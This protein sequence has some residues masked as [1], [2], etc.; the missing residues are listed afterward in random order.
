MSKESNNP[1]ISRIES[2]L[3]PNSFVELGALVTARSTDF[4]TDTKQLASDG[5]VAGHGLI[6]G[7]LVFVYSQDPSVLNGTIGEMHARKIVSIY[8][9]AMKMGAPVIGILDC[10]GIRLMESVDALE[11]LGSVY[12]A[13][14]D[15]SGVVPTITAV[16]GN[17]GGGLSVLAA[18]SDFVYMEKDAKLYLNS[19]DAISG[20]RKDKLDTSAADYQAECGNASFVGTEDEIAAAIRGLIDILPSNN[21]DD[22]VADE[23]DDDLNRATEG[24][25]ANKLDAVYVTTEIADGRRFVEIKKNYAAD[26]ITG[27]IQLDGITVGVVGNGADELTADGCEKAADFVKFC[28]AYDLPIL[29]LTNVASYDASVDGEKRL[30]RSLA[31]LAAAFTEADTAKINLITGSA[32]GTGYLFMNSKA[33]GADLVFAY[34]DCKVQAIDP[35]VA[36]KVMNIDAFEYEEKM[37]GAASAARRG[38]IDR[39]LTTADTRKYIIAGFE[40]LLSKRDDYSYRKHSTK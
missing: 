30:T 11:A 17:C 21:M 13:V 25:D 38:Y 26:M 20:S 24:L 2:L 31:R 32:V 15:A 8:E 10:A 36:A 4:N 9:K 5:V 29:S 23:C 1:A 27:F 16:Y 14:S 28:D 22:Y 33:L 19:P 39:I 34:D 3:D 37:T 6:D 12:T 7:K 40:M 18:L 35:A